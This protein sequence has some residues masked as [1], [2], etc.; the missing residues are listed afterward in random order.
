MVL[1]AARGG[2]F[3]AQLA[4]EKS[5]GDI[6][7]LFC[8]SERKERDSDAAECRFSPGC[9]CFLSVSL[10]EIQLSPPLLRKLSWFASRTKNLSKSF[11]F[12]LFDSFRISTYNFAANV[13]GHIQY[14]ESR[15]CRM[16]MKFQNTYLA[17]RA[18]YV[19]K[20]SLNLR[21]STNTFVTHCISRSHIFFKI[22]NSN[23]PSFE[24][25]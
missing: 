20:S 2:R 3:F 12:E 7:T 9:C 8:V 1:R 13:S 15:S 11:D 24:T 25:I 4:G 23:I 17:K 10:A 5:P 14:V 19:H 21:V 16:P 22:Y 6:F 18:R